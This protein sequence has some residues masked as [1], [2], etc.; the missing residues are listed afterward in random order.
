[1]E[2]PAKKAKFEDDTSLDE[3]LA[4][5][6][7]DEYL[8]AP[9]TMKQ[10]NKVAPK[11][12]LEI[13]PNEIFDS[14]FKFISPNDLASMSLTCKSLNILAKSYVERKVRCGRVRIK[15]NQN[16]NFERMQFQKFEKQFTSLIDDLFISIGT[17]ENFDARKLFQA[18]NKNCTKHLRRLH[19]V[20]SPLHTFTWED[21][22]VSIMSEQINNLEMLS[23]QYTPWFDFIIQHCNK[24]QVLIL[25]KTRSR[26]R[27]YYDWIDMIQPNLKVFLFV[28]YFLQ[29]R[30]NLENFLSNA[31]E[32]KAIGLNTLAAIMSF[33]NSGRRVAYATFSLE[34][35]TMSQVLNYIEAHH[36]DNRIESLQLIYIQTR[37]G[38]D[39]S[40]QIFQ[41][42]QQLPYVKGCHIRF[43]RLMAAVINVI[44]PHLKTLCIRLFSGDQALYYSNKIIEMFPN[45]TEISFLV[46]DIKLP[47]KELLMNFAS[48][49]KTLK[50]F[51]CS[52]NVRM[53]LTLDD[54]IEID[55]KRSE[56]EDA[57]I[58]EIEMDID[59]PT[60][61]LQKISIVELIRPRNMCVLCTIF[62]PN[63]AQCDDEE[64]SSFLKSLPIQLY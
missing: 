45:L 38:V 51:N 5:E 33:L 61:G 31:P 34:S 52:G 8:E 54:L 62:A 32:L 53:H 14:I 22:D 28:D 46:E 9:S 1:M 4:V 11:G 49:H 35:V 24:L 50:R 58:L 59:E 20:S 42:I 19:I 64:V 2:N 29:N 7:S 17:N 63:S 10:A 55:L 6:K 36:N 48:K 18:I 25:H 30:I 44:N 41:R 43:D 57:S 37:V 23:L 60:T 3:K 47:P 40:G 27:D 12:D 15:I 21:D 16:G 26:S 56:L 13:F 39:E